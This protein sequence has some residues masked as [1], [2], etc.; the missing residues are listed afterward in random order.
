MRYEGGVEGLE[1]EGG[2]LRVTRD[3]VSIV[4]KLIKS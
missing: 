4:G 1:R 3:A 2:V